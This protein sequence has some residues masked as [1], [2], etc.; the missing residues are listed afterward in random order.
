[1]VLAG[2]D[3]VLNGESLGQILFN[4]SN[5][6]NRNNFSARIKAT[7]DENYTTTSAPASLQFETCSSGATSPTERMRIKNDGSVTTF[8]NRLQVRNTV[9]SSTDKFLSGAVATSI[10][11]S[12]TERFAVF[13]DGSARFDGAV[14]A[15]NISAFRLNLKQAIQLATTLAEVKEAISTALDAL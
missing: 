11:S 7:A 3:A 2:N 5:G 15:S 12:S 13:T 1:M 10:T 4:G 14:T 9:E 6:T 8:G